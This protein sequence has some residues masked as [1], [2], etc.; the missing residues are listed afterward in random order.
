MSKASS[1][2]KMNLWVSFVAGFNGKYQM[3]TKNTENTYIS[4]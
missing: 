4:F 3:H 1:K 2:N